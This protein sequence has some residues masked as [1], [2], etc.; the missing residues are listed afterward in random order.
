MMLRTAPVSLLLTL[1][2]VSAT[3]IAC[4]QRL[5]TNARPDHYMLSLAPDIKAASFAGTETID[6]TLAAPSKTI[7]LNAIELKLLSVSAN[8]QPGDVSYD[9][10][11][12]QVV[13]TFP[14]ALPAGKVALKIAFTGVLND[15]LRGFYLS[16]TKARNYAVTQFEATDARR[17]F[18]SFDEPALKATFDVS[19][20]VD[21]GDTAISN[22]NIL[23]DTP[24]VP[25][26]AGAGKHTL[27]FATTPRMSTY[28]VAFLVGRFCLQQG[29]VGRGARFASAARRTRWS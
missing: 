8:G 1:A 24:A 23:S 25:A 20:T 12:E 14:S 5:P 9:T 13:L 28:L 21:A 10:P 15:K 18:P 3:G 2:A 19:L 6:L 7:T 17:A 11:D 27:V 4:A 16:R 22:T 26:A 29:L